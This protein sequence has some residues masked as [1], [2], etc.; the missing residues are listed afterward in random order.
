[1]SRLKPIEWCNEAH[2]LLESKGVNFNR[3]KTPRGWRGL[4]RK[5]ILEGQSRIEG[6]CFLVSLK[7]ALAMPN[8]FWYCEGLAEGKPHAWISPKAPGKASCIDVTWSWYTL[9]TGY[10]TW[11]HFKYHGVCFEP[12][13]VKA[14]M[15][16]R[17][18]RLGPD[19]TSL[20]MLKYPLEVQHLIK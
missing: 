11:G 19:S 13:D 4:A 12:L 7:I 17:M 15:L 14:F 3:M 10:K 20:S 5:D 2:R 1:M 6:N 18:E 16:E 9:T 8:T